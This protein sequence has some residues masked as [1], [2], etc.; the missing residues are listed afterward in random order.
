M[1]D[2]SAVLCFPDS[3]AWFQGYFTS[4]TGTVG[5]LGV[6]MDVDDCVR[7]PHGGYREYSLK[8]IQYETEMEVEVFVYKTGGNLC[9]IQSDQEDIRFETLNMLTDDKAEKFIRKVFPSV[10]SAATSSQVR[11]EYDDFSDGL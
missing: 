11:N 4:N 6:E 10:A 2:G 9:A 3:G 1:A 8:L 5:L 7:C